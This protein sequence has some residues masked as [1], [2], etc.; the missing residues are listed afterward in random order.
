MKEE[1]S[2]LVQ[3]TRDEVRAIKKVA[4]HLSVSHIKLCAAMVRAGVKS[5]DVLAKKGRR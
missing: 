3:L 2:V 1:S 4:K 5:L